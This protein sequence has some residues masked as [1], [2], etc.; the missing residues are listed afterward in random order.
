[1]KCFLSW[2]HNWTRWEET[3]ATIT[4]AE[5]PGRTFI[6]KIQWRRCKDCGFYQ[7]KNV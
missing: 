5:Y 6:R 2:L 7:K 3:D 1:M 4:Y